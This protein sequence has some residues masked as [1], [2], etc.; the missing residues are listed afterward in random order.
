MDKAVRDHPD[1][2][3]VRM[4]RGRNSLNLPKF[5]NRARISVL[6][7]QHVLKLT[8][9]ASAEFRARLHFNLGLAY[10]LTEEFEQAATQWQQVIRLAPD[11]PEAQQARE[12]I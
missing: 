12:K 9:N 8:K 2:I 7:F 3:E 4:L 6:D 11:S 10:E 5:F 1:D